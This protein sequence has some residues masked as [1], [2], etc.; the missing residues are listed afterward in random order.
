[1][2]VLAFAVLAFVAYK[3]STQRQVPI[4]FSPRSALL[5]LWQNYKDTT[6]EAGSS[7]AIDNSFG[8]TRTTSEGESYSMLRAVWLDD[9][10]TFDSSW[11][12]TAENLQRQNDHLFSW[13]FGQLPNGKY[14]ILIAKGGQNTAS[15]A[16]TDIA[17]S[18][19]FA[20]SR[21]ND[22]KY[23][24]AAKQIIPS[25]WDNE[26]VTV[27]GIPYLAADNLEKNASTSVV[28]NPS[29]F[30]PYAYRIFAKLDPTHPWMKLVDS[31]YSFLEKSMTANLDKQNS[32]HIP[33]DWVVMNKQTGALSAP[34]SGSSTTNM[35]FDALRI[36]WRLS[37]D[38]AW[39]KEP[40]A[41]TL[42]SDMH[43]LE[44]EWTT[45]G[46]LYTNYAHDGT[47]ITKN[48]AAAFYGGTIGYFINTNPET[49]KEIYDNK[50]IYLLD[51][52]TESWKVELGYYDD[53]WAWF[54]IALYNGLLT[55]L[56]S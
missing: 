29:Y 4:V 23:L 54:G 15:D 1:M 16:D 30:E 55:N 48:Q 28:I 39:N 11:K 52:N 19:V 45:N 9:K 17:L 21:W 37:L 3:N 7:R 34:T 32:A 25:I 6:L 20:A 43:F 27:Q 2:L 14:G 10:T 33:P 53:N 36:P 56:A 5:S 22:Q 31:S 41:K 35:S 49:A 26:V 46:L 12:F 8:D 13:L 47:A 42:L 51:P 38:L 40:R 18:L 44:N 24:D 50:L